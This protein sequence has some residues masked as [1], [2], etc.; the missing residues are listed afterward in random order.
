MKTCSRNTN[1]DAK[2]HRKAHRN[3]QNWRANAG[4]YTQEGSRLRRAESNKLGTPKI[5]GPASNLAVFSTS[6]AR[7][8]KS[9]KTTSGA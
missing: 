4:K 6:Y 1:T 5:R 3:T 7:L 9:K 2:E 8:K